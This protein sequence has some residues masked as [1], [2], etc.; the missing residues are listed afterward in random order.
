MNV[1]NEQVKTQLK[2]LGK[3]ISAR[4]VILFGSRARGDYLFNSDVDALFIV[5]GNLNRKEILSI[6]LKL[7]EF[8]E[9]DLPL[10]PIVITTTMLDKMMLNPFYWYVL[11]EGMVVQDDGLIKELLCTFHEAKSLRHIERTDTGGWKFNLDRLE[12]FLKI[13][14]SSLK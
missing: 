2:L 5:D 9:G 1:K 10:E 11:E 13:R 4:S 7:L 3:R 14:L 8:W 6:Q 12:E